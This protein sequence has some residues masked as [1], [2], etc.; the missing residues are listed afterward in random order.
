MKTWIL[1]TALLLAASAAA[2]AEL[3]VL[4][5]QAAYDP[6]GAAGLADAAAGCPPRASSVHLASDFRLDSPVSVERVTTYYTASTPESFSATAEAWLWISPKRGDLPAA[7]DDPR[8]SGRL[9]PVRAQRSGSGFALVASDL[10]LPLRPG[11]YW[12][13][14]TPVVPV[15]PRGPERHLAALRPWGRPSAGYDPCGTLRWTA[16]AVGDDATVK[17]EGVVQEPAGAAAGGGGGP[18]LWRSPR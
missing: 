2:A 5:D 11:E 14:L 18:W 3:Q 8:S 7:G 9:V 15:G 1:A 13:S 10:A 6:T 4:W 12:I 17:I 16:F